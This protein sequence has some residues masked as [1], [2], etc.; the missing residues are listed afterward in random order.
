[1][2]GTIMDRTKLKALAADLA[3]NIK[4]EAD[5]NALS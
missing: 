2:L 5:L 3:N 1:M 4:I